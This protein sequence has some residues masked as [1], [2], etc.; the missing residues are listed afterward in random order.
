MHDPS[1]GGANL[2]GANPAEAANPEEDVN[3]DEADDPDEDADP[4]EVANP[5]EEDLGVLTGLITMSLVR[6]LG[7]QGCRCSV[8]A[9]RSDVSF[10]ALIFLT[11]SIKR[12]L[13]SGSRASVIFFERTGT[14]NREKI[15][16]E[17]RCIPLGSTSSF[18]TRVSLFASD[19]LFSGT[20][21]EAPNI[22]RPALTPAG[23]MAT[24]S[25]LVSTLGSAAVLGSALMS[26]SR[27]FRT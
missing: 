23:L 7:I 19:A 27:S 4:N 2:I 16:L 12:A 25:T 3:P 9:R 15:R 21:D 6:I 20:C 1:D 26:V 17:I 5:V 18:F 22:F 14:A 8:L 13:V 24:A 10:S 11:F